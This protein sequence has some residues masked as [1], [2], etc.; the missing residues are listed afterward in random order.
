MDK[1]EEGK[2]C[3]A[4]WNVEQFLHN[5]HVRCGR[6]GNKFRQAF[7][8]AEQKCVNNIHVSPMLFEILPTI[9]ILKLTF[10]VLGHSK[11]TII[12]YRIH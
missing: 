11:L 2:H 12:Y 4:G 5:Q 9:K 7:D 10:K 1:D 3:V 8:D 6:D